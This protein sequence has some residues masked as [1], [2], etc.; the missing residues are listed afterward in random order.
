VGDNLLVNLLGIASGNRQASPSVD[1]HDQHKT[2][3]HD[4]KWDKKRG[5]KGRKHHHDE[6]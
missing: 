5:H 6:D 3:D 1:R 4:H 2:D